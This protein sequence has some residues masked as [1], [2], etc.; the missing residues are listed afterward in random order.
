MTTAIVMTLYRR[1]VYTSQVLDSV[2][3][4]REDIGDMP[5]W[6]FVDLGCDEVADLAFRFARDSG[7]RA[8]VFWSSERLGCNKNTF[9]AVDAAIDQFDSVIVL[10]DDV[11]LGRDA[12]RYFKWGLRKYSGDP[13]VFSIS[14]YHRDNDAKEQDVGVVSR[15][16][17]FVPWG[18]ATWRDRWIDVRNARMNHPIPAGV[19]W[20]TWLSENARAGRSEIYPPVS[21]TQ[22]I[23]ANGGQHVPSP[24]WHRENQWNPVWVNSLFPFSKPGVNEWSEQ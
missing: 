13:D 14:G 5:F 22:N 21:R 10:E 19:S 16:C 17:W 15:R 18:W 24:E 2:M 12:I 23:G 7:L 4:C 1:P 20:D 9:R 8:G 6:M 11:L 3:S